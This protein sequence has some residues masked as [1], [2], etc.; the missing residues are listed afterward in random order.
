MTNSDELRAINGIFQQL[1]LNMDEQ[2]DP[3]EGFF[4]AFKQVLAIKA[5]RD[6]EEVEKL[7]LELDTLRKSLDG[8]TSPDYGMLPVP[9]VIYERVIEIAQA[10]S[11]SPGVL[12]TSPRV[13]EHLLQLIE[14]ELI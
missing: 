3:I 8:Y 11:V 6:A 10:R 7:Q 12:M 4:E 9:A 14:R 1:L 5:Q 2:T 13:T